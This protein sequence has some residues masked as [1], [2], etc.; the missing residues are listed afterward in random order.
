GLQGYAGQVQHIAGYDE[1]RRASHESLTRLGAVRDRLEAAG[2]RCPIITGGGTGS[3]ALDPAAGVLTELQV[4]SYI[5]SDVEYK[6]VDLTGDG[7]RPYRSALFVYARVVSTHHADHSDFVTI[8]A[9]SKSLSM[10]GPAPVVAF[11]APV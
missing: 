1:R 9:G 4:G 2:H 11:G 3:H 7:T 5:V 8:D 10:D 6:A